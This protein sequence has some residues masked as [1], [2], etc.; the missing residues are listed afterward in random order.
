[1]SSK[2]APKTKV[3]QFTKQQ[4]EQVRAKAAEV[5]VDS[6]LKSV[7]EAQAQIGKT[8]ASV[9]EKLQNELQQLDTLRKAVALEKE[10][11]AAVHG[12]E[13]LL[14]SIEELQAQYDAKRVELEEKHSSI[15]KQYEDKQDEIARQN[16][17]EAAVEALNRSKSKLTAEAALEQEIHAAKVAERNRKEELEKSWAL[18][19]ETLKKSETEFADYK[20]QVEEFPAK[21]KAEVGKEVNI[22][23]AREKRDY[24]HTI[25]LLRKDA[26]TAK[27]MADMQIAT[28]K[29]Q[30][31]S[32]L[33]QLQQANARI[34]ES[35]S[36]VAKIAEKALE[37]ASGQRTL[38]E[39]QQFQGASRDNGAAPRKA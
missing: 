21:L 31:D 15:L 35:D 2:K 4:N 6:A 12:K 14:N 17:Q 13:A 1:M 29:G 7:S 10:E 33:A 3:E 34:A 24:E 36:K 16:E 20:K 38:S 11:L 8:L 25:A 28:L 32:A 18:R 19:E 39:L 5:T 37:S 9:G 30:L 22:A 27:Q 23:V 26:E